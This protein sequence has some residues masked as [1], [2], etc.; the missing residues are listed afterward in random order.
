MASKGHGNGRRKKGKRGPDNLP[1][2]EYTTPTPPLI[3]TTLQ[4]A[5][6][7]ILPP[8]R[9]TISLPNAFFTSPLPHQFHHSSL[10]NSLH[11]SI[12]FV[13]LTLST[14]SLSGLRVGCPST[15]TSPSID[16]VT[17]SNTTAAGSQILKFKEVVEYDGN[18]RLIITPVGN[19]FIAP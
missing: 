12:S 13:P 4:P 10:H 6:T 2:G 8:P 15:S 14:P 1:A 3:T 18:G 7:N 11:S 9:E 5:T 16:S 17:A 19:G